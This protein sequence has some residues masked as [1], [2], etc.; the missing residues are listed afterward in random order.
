MKLYRISTIR[1]GKEVVLG[2]THRN[3]EELEDLA[4]KLIS[5]GIGD[6]IVFS[7]LKKAAS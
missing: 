5:Y 6:S 3:E 7:E 1:D 4:A 2:I